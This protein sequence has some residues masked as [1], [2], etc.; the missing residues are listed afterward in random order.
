[1]FHEVVGKWKESDVEDTK[2]GIHDRV[3]DTGGEAGEGRTGRNIRDVARELG[4]SHQTLRNWVKAH[5]AG[6]LNG[7][8]TKVITPEQMESS[9]L[10][11]E[12]KRLTMELEITKKAGRRTSRGNCCEVRQQA[13]IQPHIAPF[14][15]MHTRTL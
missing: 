14:F 11:A 10:R 13:G 1:V 5:D 7:P 8:G 12:N 9:R 6:T 15:H 4:I 3:H 2:A